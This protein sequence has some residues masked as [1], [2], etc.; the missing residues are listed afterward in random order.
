MGRGA[1][2]SLFFEIVCTM[3]EFFSQ[4]F[5]VASLYISEHCNVN[6]GEGVEKIS[7]CELTAFTPY[8]LS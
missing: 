2:G 1:G 8:L 3:C 5:L 6:W 7:D 4:F